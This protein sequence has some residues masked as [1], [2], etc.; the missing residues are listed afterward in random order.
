MMCLN[1]KKYK[2]LLNEGIID[3]NEFEE[4]KKVLLNMN[5]NTS[6]S[7]DLDKTLI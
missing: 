7:D 3:Q 2:E 4:K 5:E 6:N 1:N